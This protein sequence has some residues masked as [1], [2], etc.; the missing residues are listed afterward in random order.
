MEQALAL[1]K[2]QSG[3]ALVANIN[4]VLR[5]RDVYAYSELLELQKVRDLA[6]DPAHAPVHAL[7]KLFVE[8]TYA[9]WAANRGAFPELDAPLL[10]KLRVLSLVTLAST[11]KTLPY[12][13]VMGALEVT[14][15]AELEAL[16]IAA[17][18]SGLLTARMDQRAGVIEVSHCAGRDLRPDG[19][20]LAQLR[21]TLA[22]WSTAIDGAMAAVEAQAA[23]VKRER[24]GA[25]RGREAFA[26]QVRHPSSL[27]RCARSHHA[28]RCY[29]NRSQ[30]RAWGRVQLVGHHV[31]FTVIKSFAARL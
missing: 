15:P 16:V 3:L 28:G 24:E 22:A 5:A 19:S 1:A 11:R 17:V 2:G 21:A 30:E 8:G 20:H 4:R 10:E 25:R 23:A 31:T 27:R 18:Y 29:R 12:G 26:K 14:T 13:D 9:D 7:L 6:Q